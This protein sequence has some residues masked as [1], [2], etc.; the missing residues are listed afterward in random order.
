MSVQFETVPALEIG[1]V[2]NYLR[3]LNSDLTSIDHHY[4]RLSHVWWAVKSDYFWVP[5]LIFELFKN[6]SFCKIHKA[7]LVSESVKY[8]PCSSANRNMSHYLV[9]LIFP[10]FLKCFLDAFSKMNEALWNKRDPRF[11]LFYFSPFCVSN[12]LL[13]CWWFLQGSSVDDIGD[14]RYTCVSSKVPSQCSP[15]GH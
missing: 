11:N 15:R 4:W 12:S 9:R 13:N 5:C 8:I 6:T 7:F 2:L 3:I 14:K 10:L 1:F